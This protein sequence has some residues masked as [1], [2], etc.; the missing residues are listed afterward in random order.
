LVHR[1]VDAFTDRHP[2]IRAM[3]QLCLPKNR[4]FARVSLDVLLD[5]MLARN[6]SRYADEPLGAVADRFYAAIGARRTDL[7]DSLNTTID[8][9]RRHDWLRSYADPESVDAAVARIAQRL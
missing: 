1:H 8:R 4:L 2:G 7:P 5:H 3:R 9:M 6:W